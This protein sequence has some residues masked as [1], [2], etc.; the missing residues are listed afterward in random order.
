MDQHRLRER[1]DAGPEFIDEFIRHGAARHRQVTIFEAKRCHNFTFP[2]RGDWLIRLI[3]AAQVDDG[4]LTILR[5]GA[6]V[7]LGRRSS[8][9]SETVVEGLD[10]GHKEYPGSGSKLP[11]RNSAAA[12][13]D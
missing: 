6:Q 1:F 11:A 4:F 9:D 8:R 3:L 7:A 13:Y 5:Q 2:V 12:D 10:V